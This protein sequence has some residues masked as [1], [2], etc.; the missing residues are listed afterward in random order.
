MVASSARVRQSLRETRAALEAEAAATADSEAA[1]E[2]LVGMLG[3]AG[4]A[5]SACDRTVTNMLSDACERLLADL[6]EQPRVRWRVSTLLANTLGTTRDLRRASDLIE[7]GIND[8]TEA[9]GASSPQ[10]GLS[11]HIKSRVLA[12]AGDNAAAHA[13][14][15]SARALL[16][17]G[18]ESWLRERLSEMSTRAALLSSGG[19]EAEAIAL[20]RQALDLWRNHFPDDLGSI[21]ARLALAL[22]YSTGRR[23]DDAEVLL[24]EAQ[25]EAQRITATDFPTRSQLLEFERTL[26]FHQGDYARGRAAAARLTELYA[27]WFGAADERTFMSR[28][29]SITYY[30]DEEVDWESVI[31]D[32]HELVELADASLNYPS[33]VSTTIRHELGQ[34]LREAGRSEQAASTLEEALA[35]TIALWNVQHPN[36]A[37]ARAALAAAL[38]DVN[39]IDEAREHAEAARRILASR[40]V[41]HVNLPAIDRIIERIKQQSDSDRPT[42]ELKSGMRT[43][44]QDNP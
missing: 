24:T 11:L 41:S 7:V 34:A 19:K 25:S 37:A 44:G 9:F 36:V 1:V 29:A 32:L 39:R 17:A 38:L 13:T 40:G 42:Q 10:L 20:H 16:E 12:L 23:F 4:P 18:G 30:T 3:A 6:A 8:A 14:L 22:R 27:E 33:R 26:A 28:L 2:F 5:Q 21:R 31:V 15:S 43:T 35:Q